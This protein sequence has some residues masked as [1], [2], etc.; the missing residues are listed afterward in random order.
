M[1]WASQLNDALEEVERAYKESSRA[2]KELSEFLNFRRSPNDSERLELLDYYRLKLRISSSL[3]ELWSLGRVCLFLDIKHEDLIEN[4]PTIL[5]R[6]RKYLKSNRNMSY[7]SLTQMNMKS[8]IDAI[9]TCYYVHALDVIQDSIFFV[10]RV[11]STSPMPL[12]PKDNDQRELAREAMNQWYCDHKDSLVW[13]ESLESFTRNDS[14]NNRLPKEV[15]DLFM[16]N[17]G[18]R[19]ETETDIELLQ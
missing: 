19:N 15:V 11:Y 18:S 10:D 14:F 17:G 9:S 8:N 5:R 16:G 6:Y 12:S 2:E 3:Y 4:T 1:R 7:E 13:R